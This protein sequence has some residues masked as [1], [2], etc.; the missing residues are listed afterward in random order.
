MVAPGR[1]SIW[2]VETNVWMTRSCVTSFNSGLDDS[3]EIFVAQ[4]G[5]G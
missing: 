5:R 4:D 3:D 1:V 2:N